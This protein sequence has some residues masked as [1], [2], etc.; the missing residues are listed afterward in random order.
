MPFSTCVFPAVP[1]SP[2]ANEV[3]AVGDHGG[4][5]VRD[6]V[7]WTLEAH[8]VNIAAGQ[9]GTG[10]K[11]SRGAVFGSDNFFIGGAGDWLVGK[12][13]SSPPDQDRTQ[14]SGTED[15]QL[16]KNYRRGAF[17]YFVPLADGTY[18]VTLGFLEP[19]KGT[20]VGNRVFDVVAN[21]GLAAV[22]EPS[23]HGGGI[24]R[25]ASG[26]VKSPTPQ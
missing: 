11:A 21:R 24:D 15:P 20:A 4:K 14:V 22:A 3:V 25:R 10:F 8:D 5:Q 13:T 7:R 12:S 9:L 16:Y 1:L 17:S 18:S 23:G 2:G 6:A 19:F 26:T